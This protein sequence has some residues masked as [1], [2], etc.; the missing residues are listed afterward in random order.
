MKRRILYIFAIVVFVACFSACGYHFSGSGSYP[1]GVK[2]I[3]VTL[4]ENKTAETGVE[5]TFTND[6]IYEFTRNRK[7]S[8]V[9]DRSS[10]DGIL[11]GTIARL[12]VANIT[13]TS[14]STA[15]ERRVTGTLTLRLESP[16]GRLLWNSGNI[17]ESEAYS[18]VTGDKVATDRNKSEAITTLSQK[19]AE[20][21]FNRLTEDF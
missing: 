8:L 9:R 18:V 2:H 13:R 1:A 5:S 4:L 17:V 6:L 12:S 16:E 10:A 15:T 3:F 14:V 21:A 20:S 19:L 7:E 11:S